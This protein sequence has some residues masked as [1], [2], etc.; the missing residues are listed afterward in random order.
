MQI[1]ELQPV[2]VPFIPLQ[3][4]T[5]TPVAERSTFD[6]ILQSEKLRFSAHAQARLMSRGVGLTSE[7]MARLEDAVAKAERKGARDAFVMLRDMVFIVSI[8][9]RTVI[10]ALK[11]DQA[12]ENIFTNIDAAVL[13]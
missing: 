3:P 11:A 13:V 12:Q 9:N 4:P 6:A 1:A 8:K 7:D 10:T 2:A 5:Q